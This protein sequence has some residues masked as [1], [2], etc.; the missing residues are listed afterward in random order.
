VFCTNEKRLQRVASTPLPQ[1]LYGHYLA[2]ADGHT[3]PTANLAQPNVM[4]LRQDKVRIF[5]SC[6]RRAETTRRVV[7]L[8][9]IAHLRRFIVGPLSVVDMEFGG[10][11]REWR[12]R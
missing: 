8:G 3:L 4:A 5:A 6:F 2:P 1:V 11:W 7:V 9:E 10:G 12:V